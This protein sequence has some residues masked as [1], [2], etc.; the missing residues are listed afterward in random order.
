MQL[1]E[2]AYVVA[3]ERQLCIS[4]VRHAEW[5]SSERKLNADWWEVLTRILAR[6]EAVD[7]TKD[8]ATIGGRKFAKYLI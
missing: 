6:R 5:L 1:L 8:H 3:S 2:L 7:I 4:P